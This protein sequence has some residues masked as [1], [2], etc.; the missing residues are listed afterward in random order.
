VFDPN[1]AAETNRETY[2]AW[3]SYWLSKGRTLDDAV[4]YGRLQGGEAY[5]NQLKRLIEQMEASETALA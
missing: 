1:S 2:N 5:A 4:E 3:K